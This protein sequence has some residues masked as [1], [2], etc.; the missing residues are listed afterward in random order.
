MRRLALLLVLLCLVALVL[1]WEWL[2][3]VAGLGTIVTAAAV[4]V[5]AELD[6]PPVVS[7]RDVSGRCSHRGAR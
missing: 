3:A 4:H 5:L 2:L 7:P 1:D 6:D